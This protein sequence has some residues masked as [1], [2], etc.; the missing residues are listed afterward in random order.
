MGR[1]KYPP[2]AIKFRDKKFISVH[3]YFGYGTPA[4]NA[5]KN[6]LSRGATTVFIVPLKS[7]VAAGIYFYPA[8]EGYGDWV[9]YK[10]ARELQKGK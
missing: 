2:N 1:R 9:E 4:E 6:L 5:A 10:S 7:D 8:I 3:G